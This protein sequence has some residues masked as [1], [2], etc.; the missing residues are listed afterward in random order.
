[1]FSLLKNAGNALIILK[2]SE[3]HHSISKSHHSSTFSRFKD[4]LFHPDDIVIGKFLHEICS[5]LSSFHSNLNHSIWTSVDEII[6]KTRKLLKYE[7]LQLLKFWKVTT[8]QAWT[9]RDSKQGWRLVKPWRFMIER[10]M[11]DSWSSLTTHEPPPFF[12][13]VQNSFLSTNQG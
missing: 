12:Q 2:N 9:T 6:P 8:Q 10:K 1:M 5:T 11:D 4:I 3:R 7:K 13:Q